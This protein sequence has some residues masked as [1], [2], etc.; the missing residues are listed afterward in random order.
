MKNLTAFL[1]ALILATI[2]GCCPKTGSEPEEAYHWPSDPKVS[3]KLEAWQDWKFGVIIHWGPYSEWGIVESWS[4]CPEDEPWCERRGPFAENYCAYVKEYEKIRH[5]FN[6]VKFDPERWAEACHD[7]GM[8]Y[9]VFTTK[10]HDGFCMYDSKYTDYKITATE[11]VFSANPR[12]N[13]AD[14][15][16]T[17]FRE[18]GMGVGVYFS[19]ADWHSDDYW[20]PYFPVFDRNVNYDPEKYPERWQRFK[21]FTF[22]QL[23][24]LM[25]D[26]GDVDIL[27]LDGGWVRP[28]GTLTEETR[29]WLGKNQWVQD[30]N[31]PAIAT[32]ARTQQPGL[33]IVDRTVH[34]EF[35]NYRTPE[36]Q[37]PGEI[38]A[39]PWES[40]I[41]LGDSWYHTGERERY[42]SATW[43]IQ[44]LV[45]IVAKGG[46]LLLGIGPDNT[47][48]MPPEVYE[49]LEAIGQWM[50]IN[51]Q[52]IYETKPL[53]PYQEG[54]WC[55]TQSKD[56]KTRY[57]F[58]L[59]DENE[60][61]LET[62]ELPAGFVEQAG[63][64]ELLG[65]S[66]E[67]EVRREN[68]RNYLKVPGDL[69]EMGVVVFRVGN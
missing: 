56:C 55:F 42:K 15:V 23:E 34:G 58:Y 4:L 14:E 8:K 62:L 60:T 43:A 32:M 16:F 29:P 48:A 37:I 49:R 9:L 31:M 64:L 61:L 24:E 69:G 12:S 46:N 30:I 17:A 45:K 59:K 38:P 20:W 1:T 47:G 11:S 3:A 25:T 50:N 63:E 57:A 6:P 54:K 51:A 39:Y 5:S 33:L 19:K 53:A 35:E 18:K 41:T 10:H 2:M 68:G 52:A 44:T 21:N 67:L 40:C 65:Y 7:A 28:A 13:I 26:Y 27:W 22:K 66:G 36:Q